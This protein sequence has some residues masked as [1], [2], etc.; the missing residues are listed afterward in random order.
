MDTADL[1]QRRLRSQAISSPGVST[2]KEAV[3]RLTAVQAQY[4]SSSVWAIGLRSRSSSALDIERAV[5]SREIVRTWLMRGTLHF[6]AAEDVRWILDLVAPRLIAGSRRR[7]EQLHLDERTLA[8]CKDRISMAMQ[9]G[10]P[11]TRRE[12][13]DILEKDGITTAGQRG[14]HILWY[15]AI[16]GLI[17]FGPMRDREPT[18]VLL[19]EWL[20]QKNHVARSGS[21]GELARRYFLGHG[22]A[23]L[24]DLAWWSGLPISVAREAINEVRH[25]LDEETINGNTYWSGPPGSPEEPSPSLHLLPGYDEYIIGYRDRDAVLDR[26]HTKEVL[27]SNGVFYPTVVIDGRVSG[28]WRTVRARKG[29]TIE[30][31]PF[32]PLGKENVR[33]LKEVTALYEHFLGRSHTL[34]VKND[35]EDVDMQWN[36]ET[37]RSRTKPSE[38]MDN[39]R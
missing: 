36:D 22:P 2:P 8:R 3:T 33:S 38:K 31:M 30:V 35:R 19:D 23:K 25:L 18:F 12:L 15:L 20:P 10:P 11:F 32:S 28:T 29:L 39:V 37:I 6:A 16:T 4:H 17:C 24:E 34:K 26:D 1:V 7:K 21:V 9:G 13:M 5:A 27:S 14:Y